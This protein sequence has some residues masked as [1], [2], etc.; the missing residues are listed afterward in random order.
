MAGIQ[1]ILAII[2]GNVNVLK[3]KLRIRI[4]ENYD[5]CDFET[6]MIFGARQQKS[7]DEANIP[8]TPSRAIS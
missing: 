6:C 5:L 1:G 8:P 2:Y 7:A 4:R 3:L